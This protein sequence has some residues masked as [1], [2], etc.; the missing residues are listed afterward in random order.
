MSTRLILLLFIFQIEEINIV[1]FAFCFAHGKNDFVKK[2][3]I[4]NRI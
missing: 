2:S 1:C 4:L 3:K